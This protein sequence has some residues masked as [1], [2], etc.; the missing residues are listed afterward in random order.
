MKNLSFEQ[1]EELNGGSNL[2]DCISQTAGGMDILFSAGAL[3]AFGATP[4]GWICLG[5]GAIG[6]TASL[7]SN[8]YACDRIY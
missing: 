5:F 1:M 2:L 6:L 7:L 3:L 8:P 4:V